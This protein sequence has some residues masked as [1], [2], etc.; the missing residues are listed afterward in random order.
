V[1]LDTVVGAFNLGCSAEE[2]VMKYP[3]LQLP[4]VYAVITY[5]LHH[6]EDV[7]DYL[8]QRRAQAEEIRRK[9]EQQ[10]PTQGIRERLLARRTQKRT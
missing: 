9:I 2:I 6:R 1:S 5:Y 4:D 8:E 3:S 10:F 7:E